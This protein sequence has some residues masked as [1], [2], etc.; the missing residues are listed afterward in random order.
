MSLLLLGTAIISEVFA[1]SML[2]ATD[3]FKK[4]IPTLGVIIGYIIAFYTLSVLLKTMP[5]GVAYAI[6]AGVGTALT[7]L[8]GMFIYKEKLNKPKLAGLV[9]IIGGVFLINFTSAI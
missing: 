8:V 6:W 2:K 4:I 1:S 5:I 3:G 9:L 7:A